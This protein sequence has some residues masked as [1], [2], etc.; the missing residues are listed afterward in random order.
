V[1]HGPRWQ[2]FV[3]IL[4]SSSYIQHIP[5]QVLITDAGFPKSC[6][7]LTRKCLWSYHTN[8]L[9]GKYIFFDF[10]SLPCGRPPLTSLS[11][12]FKIWAWLCVTAKSFYDVPVLE[13]RCFPFKSHILGGPFWGRKARVGI[14][15]WSPPGKSAIPGPVGEKK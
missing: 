9:Y 2:Y 12:H 4:I 11:E 14:F 5:K 13:G 15:L 10:H 7:T 8:R 3:D 6:Q 1:P